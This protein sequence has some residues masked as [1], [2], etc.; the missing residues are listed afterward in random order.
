MVTL[1]DFDVFLGLNF[2]KKVK[3]VLMPHQDG[4]LVVNE[5]CPCFVPCHKAVVA[6]S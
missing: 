2:L 1:D 3:I 4:I 6:E 5:L